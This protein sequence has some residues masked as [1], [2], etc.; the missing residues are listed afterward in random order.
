MFG[1]FTIKERRSE[2][3]RYVILFTCFSS[4]AIH[5]ETTISMETDSFI[6][7]LRRF[8]GRRGD[9][10]SIR[11]EGGNFVGAE[12]ELKKA[13]AELD[14]KKVRG[15]LQSKGANWIEWQ[16]NPFM[17]ATWAECGSGKFDRYVTYDHLS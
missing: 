15:F 8:I 13:L 10:R 6:C 17:Q 1:P 9:V 5:L 16:R 14:H 2:L 4:R 7:A 12:N 11:S 3:K